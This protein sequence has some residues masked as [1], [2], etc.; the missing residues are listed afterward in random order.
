MQAI[1]KC[2]FPM[3]NAVNLL[4]SCKPITCSNKLLTVCYQAT[5]SSV[6]ATHVTRHMQTMFS[7]HGL[8]QKKI[9]RTKVQEDAT[10]AQAQVG[11][12]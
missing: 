8:R 12:I 11:T 9:G 4:V 7:E 10:H 5:F 3:I 1:W 2:F 6:T